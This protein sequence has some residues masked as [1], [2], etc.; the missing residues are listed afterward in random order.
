MFRIV[1][2]LTNCG[3]VGIDLEFNGENRKT[4]IF[5]FVHQYIIN[6]FMKQVLLIRGVASVEYDCYN[7][8]LNLNW[9]I[10]MAC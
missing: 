5:R 3:V 6:H 1:Y 7:S 4:L 2:S 9:S 10:I 8:Q